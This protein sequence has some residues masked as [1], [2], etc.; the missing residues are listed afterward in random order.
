MTTP[1]RRII[2]RNGHVELAD[3]ELTDLPP[4]HVR[5]RTRYSGVSAGTELL[6]LARS[7]GN[8]ALNA[9]GY[10]LTGTVD[11]VADD[12]ADRFSPGDAVVCYGGPYVSHTSLVS[13]PKHLLVKQPAG[14]DPIDASFCALGVIALNAFRRARLSLGETAAVVGLGMLGNITAQVARAGGCRVA[15]ADRLENR[16]T[17]AKACGLDAHADL[18]SLARA[19]GD[20]TGS[21][22]ADAAFVVVPNCSDDLLEKA[23]RLC[24]PQGHVVIVGTAN[25]RMP[26]DAM[27]Q[28]EVTVS[29]SRAAGPGRYDREYEAGGRDYPYAYV[30]WTE[31][32]N[33]EEFVRLLAIGAVTVRPL[34][35]DIVPVASAPQVYQWL[36]DDPAGHVGVVFDWQA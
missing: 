13:V 18:E 11:S 21:N 33:L 9:M 17:A 4:G 5:V 34:V 12:L 29:V 31:G 28:T 32:R 26:R 10:Q 30:R 8:E 19:I 3:A 23:V 1:I 36:L 14:A 22:M 25:A 24:R 16:R 35:T 27:F 20:L 6:T 7:K 15:C 2:A